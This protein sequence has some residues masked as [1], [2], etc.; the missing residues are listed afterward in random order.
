MSEP[1]GFC[2]FCKTPGWEICNHF[3]GY[4]RRG[5]IFQPTLRDGGMKPLGPK[6][7]TVETGVSVRVYNPITKGLSK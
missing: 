5:K 1:K 7:V 3:V 2:P 6:D 4:V